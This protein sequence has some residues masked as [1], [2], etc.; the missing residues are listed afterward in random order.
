MIGRHVMLDIET[1]GTRPG[2]AI[3]SIAAVA[4]DFDAGKAVN[5]SAGDASVGK[6]MVTIDLKSNV[7]AKMQLNASTALWWM[8]HEDALVNWVAAPKVSLSIALDSF[9][10]YIESL[11]I[12]GTDVFIWGNSNRFDMGLMEAAYQALDKKIPWKFRNE[13]DVRTL[14]G[15]APEIKEAHIKAAKESGQVLHDPLVDATLQIAYCVEIYKKLLGIPK[16]LKNYPVT[17]GSHTIESI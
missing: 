16:D 4:F 6:F 8:E 12:E 17:K 5:Y 2:S 1:L 13:R 3:M 10:K 15:F 7:E 9:T 11:T 14:V